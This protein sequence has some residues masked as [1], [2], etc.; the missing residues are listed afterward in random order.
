MLTSLNP[1]EREAAR[2]IVVADEP[3]HQRAGDDGQDAGR[4]QQA[5]SPFR[6]RGNGARHHGREN[7]PWRLTEVSVA[8]QQQFDPGKNMK[9]KERRDPDAAGDQRHQYLDEESRKTK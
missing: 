6:R 1:A 4:G 3:D 5:P 7:R 9:Q 2:A 8:R